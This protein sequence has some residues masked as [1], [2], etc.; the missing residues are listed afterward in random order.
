V[1]YHTACAIEKDVGVDAEFTTGKS[2]NRCT[3]TLI[4]RGG[5]IELAGRVWMKETLPG[6]RLSVI[7][8]TR[9]YE[10]VVG[11][12]RVAFGEE[13]ESLYVELIPSFRHP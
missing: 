1:E 10:N 3:A 12:A 11:E 7:G 8:G 2:L 6:F 4:L 9:T 5:T 13:D